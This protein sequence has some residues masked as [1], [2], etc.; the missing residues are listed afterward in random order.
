MSEQGGHKHANRFSAEGDFVSRLEGPERKA[1]LPTDDIVPRLG[2][3]KTDKAL[4][5]GAGI[6]YFSIPM[7]KQAG[8]VVS[9]DIEPKMHEVLSGRIRDFGLDNIDLLRG[10]ITS[11]PIADGA[12]D[13]VFAAFVY[14]EVDDP[15]LLMRESA[16]VLRKDG[17]LTVVDFQKRETSVGPPVSE[18]K[19]PEQVMDTA[20]VSLRFERRDETDVYYQLRFRRL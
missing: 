8:S 3:K 6:G 16:R 14:H 7:S 15:G 11:L 19:T 10:E 1:A 18:R 13:Q 17:V 2:L 20:P 5:L 4:D 12:A 9:V